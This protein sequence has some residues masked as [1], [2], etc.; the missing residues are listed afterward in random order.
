MKKVKK[1]KKVK[2]EK[3]E[4]EAKRRGKSNAGG[5]RKVRTG[6]K[7]EQAESE[8][9]PQNLPPPK[10]RAARRSHAA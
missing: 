10:R 3:K 7:K 2:K 1:V 5:R 6:E 4:K 9:A 8:T